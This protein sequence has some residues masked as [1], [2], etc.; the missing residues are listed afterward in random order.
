MGL[1]KEEFRKQI[2][3]EEERT[4]LIKKRSEILFY[5]TSEIYARASFK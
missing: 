3:P 4:E 2:F 5:R 1:S